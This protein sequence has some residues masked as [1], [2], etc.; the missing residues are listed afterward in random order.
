MY[1]FQTLFLVVLSEYLINFSGFKLSFLIDSILKAF[2][3]MT[4]MLKEWIL[5]GIQQTELR[6]IA[7]RVQVTN[8]ARYTFSE[9]LKI[10][11]L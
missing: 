5:V 2:S 10:K 6:S 11:R 8:T 1:R 4:L 9:I 3:Y 7:K